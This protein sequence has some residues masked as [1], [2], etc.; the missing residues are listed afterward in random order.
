MPVFASAQCRSTRLG[1]DA[2]DGLRIRLTAGWIPV[3]G[4]GR[5]V[6]DPR[7]LLD[8]T[9][10]A[11][12][13]IPAAISRARRF[14]AMAAALVV[15]AQL[16]WWPLRP[17]WLGASTAGPGLWVVLPLACLAGVAVGLRRDH[18]GQAVAGALGCALLGLVIPAAAGASV[19]LRAADLLC[20]PAAVVLTVYSLA[21]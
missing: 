7:T 12:S 21:V 19:G 2:R 3:P 11:A 4:P 20:G 14:D 5:R 6:V 16:A 18:P 15:V 17:G 9:P 8:V 10:R 1:G 13:L